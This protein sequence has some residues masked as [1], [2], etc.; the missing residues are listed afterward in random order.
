MHSWFTWLLRSGAR[1]WDVYP[2]VCGPPDEDDL[3]ASEE[4]ESLLG[5][6]PCFLGTGVAT[7][8]NG[9]YSVQEP[10]ISGLTSMPVCSTNCGANVSGMLGTAATVSSASVGE[11]DLHGLPT[12][13]AGL[14]QDILDGSLGS[15]GE[16]IGPICTS[17]LE[18]SRHYHYIHH[19]SKHQQIMALPQP[20]TCVGSGPIAV[21]A[22]LS[23]TD[24]SIGQETAL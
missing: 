15:A 22:S 8:M 5:F 12:G 14:E 21:G 23:W 13:L 2:P 6:G 3:I 16:G 17:P 24:G 19:H 9:C 20:F 7:S 1:R 18:D 11:A 10:G 4:H